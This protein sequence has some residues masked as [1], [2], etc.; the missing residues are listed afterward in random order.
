MTNDF[1][2]VVLAHLGNP[3]PPARSERDV[4]YA[5]IR[6]EFDAMFSGET[7]TDEHEASALA[8]EQAIETIEA[9]LN[10]AGQTAAV[11]APA[12]E[13]VEKPQVVSEPAATKAQ[14]QPIRNGKAI[15]A[16][17]AAIAVLAAGAWYVLSERRDVAAVS[18]IVI[19]QKE[20]S[21]DLKKELDPPATDKARSF[22]EAL[23]DSDAGTVAFLMQSG[24]RPTRVEL[25]SA[26]LQMKYTSQIQAA[27]AELAPDIRDIACGF[28]SFQDV[29]K[30]MT[31]PR[32]FDAEDAFA[33]MKQMG[34]DLWKTTCATD[35][36]ARFSRP[37][38]IGRPGSPS[39]PLR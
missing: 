27:T 17:A 36:A 1:R 5:R 11:A 23:R 13:P 21:T 39:L 15:A 18:G 19:P 24:Y 3:P 33:I 29:H 25:R 10:A 12:I 14:T 34:Q 8:L 6:S 30:P 32:L 37:P 9:E 35:R 22:L 20:A 7:A 16:I 2:A 31:P 26:L 38:W 4:V 28:T